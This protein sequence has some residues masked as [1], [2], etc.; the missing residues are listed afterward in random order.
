[1]GFKEENPEQDTI[2]EVK[3]LF[4]PE[5][6]NR[7]DAIVPFHY[8]ETETILKI[9]DKNIKQLRKQ[10]SSKNITLTISNSAK[11]WLAKEGYDRVMGARPMERLIEEQLKKPLA[12]ELLFGRFS[13]EGGEVRIGMENARLQ[14]QIAAQSQ[15]LPQQPALTEDQPEA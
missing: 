2:G 7:L 1:M 9:V 4:S 8:L 14:I 6:R 15:L 3:Q 13:G 10:L 12:E 11:Q 5:F